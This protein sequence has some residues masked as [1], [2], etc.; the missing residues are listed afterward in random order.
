MLLLLFFKSTWE[1]NVPTKITA[2][3]VMS[4]ATVLFTVSAYSGIDHKEMRFLYPVV[5]VL[6]AVSA[7][8]FLHHPLIHGGSDVRR[9]I[10]LLKVMGVFN[11]LLLLVLGSAYRRGPLDMM[12]ELRFYPQ[13][14]SS[15]D[16]LTSCYNLPGYSHAHLAVDSLRGVDCMLRL[17]GRENLEQTPAESHL[18]KKPTE[19]DLFKFD[20]LA[21]VEWVYAASTL[22][23]NKNKTLVSLLNATV[24]RGSWSVPEA[25]ILYSSTAELIKPFLTRYNFTMRR[26]VFHTILLVEDDE[27]YWI[28]LWQRN[29]SVSEEKKETKE[30]KKK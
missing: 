17:A 9:P 14:I 7:F 5:P 19:T 24:R 3:L 18:V 22:P 16:V 21:F 1:I 23:R 6:I 20:P 25:V 4:C 15:V 27:D 2:K 29:I 12:G 13:K 30:K 28:E 26:T 10:K 8:L 11:V